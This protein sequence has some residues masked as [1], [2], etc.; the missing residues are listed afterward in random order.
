MSLTAWQETVVAC[1][2]ELSDTKQQKRS[3]ID[4]DRACFPSP[5]EL[6]CQLF[7]DS[8]LGDLLEA[9]DVA[10][11]PE[12]DALLG[13]LGR[14]IDDVRLDQPVA[15]LIEDRAWREVRSLAKEALRC[16]EIVMRIRDARGF[17]RRTS[18]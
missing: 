8:G 16:C 9:G 2:R 18:L 14:K 6:V 1:L 5:E 11:S 4:K 7:D 15:S 3:W 10:F 13:E 17:R 12:C